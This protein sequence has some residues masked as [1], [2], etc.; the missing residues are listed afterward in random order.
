GLDAVWELDVFGGLRRN[1]EA[2]GANIQAA[3]ENIRDVQMSLVA[4]VALNYAQLRG[5]QQQVVIAQENLVAQRHTAEITRQK[6]DAGLVSGLDVANANAQVATTEA[7]VPL[8]ETS[9]RQAIYALSVLL[10]RQ[11]GNLVAELSD[12]GPLPIVPGE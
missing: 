10:A 1:V 12:T 9:A 2:A 8:L 7:Q 6:F 11:P 5:Y 3:R 4:E